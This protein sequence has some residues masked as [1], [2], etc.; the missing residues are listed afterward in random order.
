V[1]LLVYIWKNTLHIQVTIQIIGFLRLCGGIKGHV[2]HQEKS[3]AV[4]HVVVVR[5]MPRAA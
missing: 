3:I 1:L 5:A 2:Q 4:K